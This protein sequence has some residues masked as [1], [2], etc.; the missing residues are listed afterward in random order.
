MQATKTITLNTTEGETIFEVQ[1]LDGVSGMLLLLQLSKI[2]GPALAKQGAAKSEMLI[3]ALQAVDPNQY[4]EIQNK[5]LSRSIARIPSKSLVISDVVGQLGELFTGR[6][7]DLGK[8]FLFGIEVNFGNFFEG[9][10][11][12]AP[13]KTA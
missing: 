5:I 6:V 10:R 7:M 4:L 2:L 1:Q 13:I 11:G 9:K 12:P 8:L 3:A